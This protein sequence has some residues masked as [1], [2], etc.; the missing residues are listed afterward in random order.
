VEI[1]TSQ[2]TDFQPEGR[3]AAVDAHDGPKGPMLAGIRGLRLKVLV[4]NDEPCLMRHLESPTFT[5]PIA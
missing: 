1:L 3:G 4:G 5:S 2:L